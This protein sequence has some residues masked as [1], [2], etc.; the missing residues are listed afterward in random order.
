MVK[1]ELISAVAEKTGASKKDT[2]AVIKTL[3]DVII[4]AVAGGDTV[5]LYGLGSFEAAQK[6]ARTCR[7]P[8]TGEAIEVAAHKLPKFKPAKAFKDAVNTD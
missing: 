7:N 8:Q 5:S 2:E 1:S 3:C 6:S 4:E